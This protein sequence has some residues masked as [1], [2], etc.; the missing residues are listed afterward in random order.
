[1]KSKNGLY[2]IILSTKRRISQEPY[3]VLHMEESVQ[4][5][6]KYEDGELLTI[7]W[8]WLGHYIQNIKNQKYGSWLHV[9]FLNIN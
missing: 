5:T 9:V 8:R 7:K 1:M 6:T 3:K 2:V 4:R